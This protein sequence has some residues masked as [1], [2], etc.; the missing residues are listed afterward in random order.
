M[1]YST[2]QK[3]V[4]LCAGI[5][6]CCFSID[7]RQ[8]LRG[9]FTPSLKLAHFVLYLKIINTLMEKKKFASYSKL[10]KELKNYI[11]GSLATDQNTIFI[12]LI[13]NHNCLA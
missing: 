13:H 7:V 10:S 3:Q 5:N 8:S 2:R 12:V 6:C 4:C 11:S 1:G 9:Y